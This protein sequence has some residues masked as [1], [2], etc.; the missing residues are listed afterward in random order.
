MKLVARQDLQRRMRLVKKPLARMRLW[1]RPQL[2][3]R[4]QQ[5]IIIKLAARPKQP[6][7]VRRATRTKLVARQRLVSRLEVR[8]LNPRAEIFSLPISKTSSGLP[9]MD[10][11]SSDSTSKTRALRSPDSVIWINLSGTAKSVYHAP[12]TSTIASGKRLA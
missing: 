5:A 3:A 1:V 6:K 10:G 9:R 12:R 7:R 2:R 8:R 11:L 4:P